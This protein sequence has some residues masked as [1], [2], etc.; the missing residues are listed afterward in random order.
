MGFTAWPGFFYKSDYGCYG[1]RLNVN[2][3]YLK[4]IT[5]SVLRNYCCVF[6]HLAIIFLL[7]FGFSQVQAQSSAEFKSAE[8]VR[9][10][11]QQLLQ[12]QILF[13]EDQN[14]LVESYYSRLN[15]A[16]SDQVQAEQDLQLK[17]SQANEFTQLHKLKPSSNTQRQLNQAQHGWK[18]A[19][20]VVRSR[21]KRYRRIETKLELAQA[22]LNR[23]KQK[24][25]TLKQQKKRQ[26]AYIIN[27]QRAKKLELAR[28]EK[29]EQMQSKAA[30][31]A[32]TVAE[33]SAQ[34]LEVEAAAQRLEAEVQAQLLVV[35]QAPAG[36]AIA[37]PESKL[38][39]DVASLDLE[40]I[41]Q[42]QREEA[43]LRRLLAKR[44]TVR[45]IFK[46]LLL[47]SSRMAPIKFDHMGNNMYRAEARVVAGKQLF[48]VATTDFR[49]SIPSVDDGEWYVFIYDARRA[50]RG[51]L[52]MYKRSLLQK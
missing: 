15:G 11:I 40:A 33:A 13:V 31:A 38:S 39:V 24:L 35:D 12:N 9:Q 49:T 37:K 47:R 26:G 28:A 43:R 48:E 51:R 19:Q 7:V 32:A 46:S 27:L 23:G 52:S 8:N 44:K 41:A 6:R 42:A 50:S 30:A 20:R 1:L 29:A 17:K 10:R 18:I 5:I 3:D 45:P 16:K 21:I 25:D 34:R 4:V 14:Q 22:E 2:D 36:K